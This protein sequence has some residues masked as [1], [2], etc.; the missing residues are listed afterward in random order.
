M[1]RY[2]HSGSE[3]PH[4]AAQLPPVPVQP[5]ANLLD[6]LIGTVPTPGAPINHPARLP[7]QVLPLVPGG[8]PG[9]YHAARV[10]AGRRHNVI[11]SVGKL[12]DVEI[13]GQLPIPVQAGGGG[14]VETVEAAPGSQADTSTYYIH[15]IPLYTII[16]TAAYPTGE[17]ADNFRRHAAAAR[18]ARNDLIALWREE[19]KRLPG[20]RL[21]KWQ[22]RP[23]VNAV[24]FNA[25]PW[26]REVSQNAVKG[27]MLD[28]EDAIARYHSGQNRRPRFHGKQKP[29]SFR[30]DNGPD[31]VKM[32]GQR[33]LLPAKMGGAVKVKEPLRWPGKVIR[34]CRIKVK[35]GRWYASVGMEIEAEDY[36]WRCGDGAIGLDLGL[37]TFVTIA[38]A[39][40]R[41]E[42]VDAP[43]P[44]RRSLKALRRANRRKSR[45]K[46]G[47]RNRAK[48]NLSVAKKHS[49]MANIRKDFLHKLS[50]RL[51]AEAEV[52][53]VESL[54]IRG[55]Q[56]MWGRKTSDLAPAEFLRQLEYKADWRGGQLVKAAWHYPS[57]QICHGCGYRIGKLPLDVRRWDCPGCGD[58]ND[59]DGNAA[60]NLRDYETPEAIRCLPVDA[61]RKTGNVPAVADEAGTEADSGRLTQVNQIRVGF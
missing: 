9:V 25:H 5:G 38:H 40:D 34:G 24:K 27:G 11:T 59:R 50:H 61:Y 19:G 56:R 3:V 2:Y 52:V 13:R 53:Q 33:L 26:M 43:E 8:D 42:K 6:H 1:L 36:G 46:L 54:S 10:I 17:Q 4:D 58:E 51:T 15:T 30:A 23:A 37:S 31:T 41:I 48:A 28:A 32:D 14:L 55:W 12:L 39:D 21:G 20:F 16:P 47:S 18:I 44:L 49:R 57:S 45:R 29:L 22:R 60:L 7:V 35:A